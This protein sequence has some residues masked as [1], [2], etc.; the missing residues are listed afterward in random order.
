MSYGYNSNLVKE[1][2]DDR[3]LDYRMHLIQMLMNARRSIEV[4]PKKFSCGCLRDLY[5]KEELRPI[6]FVGHSILILQ[7]SLS[8]V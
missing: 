8:T 6:I 7:A 5:S 2:V 4:R 3:F 1:A